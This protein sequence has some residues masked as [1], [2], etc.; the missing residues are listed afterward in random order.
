MYLRDI[1]YN[2][3]LQ[4]G[5]REMFCPRATSS[6]FNAEW[7]RTCGVLV[8][9]QFCYVHSKIC[10]LRRL[11]CRFYSEFDSEFYLEHCNCFE[12]YNFHYF[13]SKMYTLFFDIHC[14]NIYVI[15]QNETVMIYLQIDLY[16]LFLNSIFAFIL[17]YFYSLLIV[18]DS[19]N[20]IFVVID[21][22]HP[23]SSFN[24]FHLI[25]SNSFLEIDFLIIIILFAFIF[26]IL[27][28]LNFN[29]KYS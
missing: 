3:T 25:L 23:K 22:C 9:M 17:T 4:Y 5:I 16:Y 24:Y 20:S 2:S 18:I 14:P 28:V 8:Q 27:I 7:P 11:G 1:R 12:I 21:S 6:L 13:W 19:S 10:F 26:H 29:F 15:K